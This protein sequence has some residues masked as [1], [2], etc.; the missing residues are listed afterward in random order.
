M[1]LYILSAA[2]TVLAL[3]GCKNRAFNATSSVGNGNRSEFE[4][5]NDPKPDSD[6]DTVA[7]V[8]NVD[9]DFVTRNDSSPDS[10]FL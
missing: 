5:A 10:D 8:S 3:T 1:K 4:L 6:F 7:S 2:L 9:G